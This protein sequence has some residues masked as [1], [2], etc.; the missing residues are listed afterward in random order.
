MDWKAKID[1][2]Y[3]QKN[4]KN[5]KTSLEKDVFQERLIAF[6]KDFICQV[7]GK[8][9]AGPYDDT[10]EISIQG[11]PETVGGIQW[12]KPSDMEKCTVCGHWAHTKPEKH[13]YKGICQTCAEKM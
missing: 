8:P 1:K 2:F 4:V 7:C 10:H 12:D 3:D 13:I 11:M 5:K 6:Q 9:S